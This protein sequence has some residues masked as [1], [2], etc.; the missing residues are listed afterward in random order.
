MSEKEEYC[1]YCGSAIESGTQFCQNCGAALSDVE[2]TP[3][4]QI[5]Q[6]PPPASIG[7]YQQPTTQQGQYHQQTTTVY[8]P[9]KKTED[10]LGVLSLI[11]GILGWIMVLPGI[12]SIIAII[13]GHISRSRSKSVTGLVGLILGYSFIIVVGI[14][15]MVIFIPLYI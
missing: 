10:V 8:V 3:A 13:L 11:M 5:I 7:Y 15:L 4:V 14:I 6:T 9:Q 1:P 12:G 2:K